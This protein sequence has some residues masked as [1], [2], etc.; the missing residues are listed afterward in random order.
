ELSVD[1]VRGIVVHSAVEEVSEIETS[2][3][4]LNRLL[5]NIKWSQ[6]GNF[7]GVP[8]DCPQRDERLGWTGD[9]HAF[10]R[11]ATY[12]MNSADFYQKWLIDIR[13]AQGDDG[14]FPDIAP[15]VE[16]FGR[17]HVFF[18]DGGVILPWTLYRAYGDRRI[19]ED[20]YDAM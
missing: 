15:F 4:L 2:H 8:L 9:A 6:R 18:G 11:T 20:H 1:Q 10:A 16:H 14:A 5:E 13:D 17:G 19:I 3:T 12:N 7:F